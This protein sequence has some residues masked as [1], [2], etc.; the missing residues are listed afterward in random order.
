MALIFDKIS[1]ISVLFLVL[2]V[3]SFYI[4]FEGNTGSFVEFKE[5]RGM[6]CL[7]NGN[8]I[9][10]VTSIMGWI[11]IGILAFRIYKAQL[12]K[13]KA[14]KIIVVIL[15]G[16]FSFSI[17]WN[18]FNT[19]VQI[20]ILPLGVWILYVF[21]KRKDGRWKKYRRFAWLGFWAN[22]ILLSMALI[23]IPINHLVYPKDQPLTYVANVENVSIVVIHPSA[24]EHMLVKENLQK[25]IHNLK[26]K[27]FFSDEWYTE[28]YMEAES[29]QRKERFPYLLINTL[30]KWGSGLAATIY[31]EKD[32]KGLLIAT[33]NKQYY[34]H[35]DELLIEEGK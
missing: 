23:A 1:L 13:P 17:N 24:N 28:T 9:E 19:L 12:E 15:V 26:P 29:S 22:F 11:I 30:P 7:W 33:L 31:I 21:L 6:I 27:T 8:I 20:A 16:L 35:S 34:F 14:W 5:I 4:S 3:T 32:G 25:Q 18:V 2:I 10:I